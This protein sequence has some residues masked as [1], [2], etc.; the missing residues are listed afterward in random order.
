MTN[1]LG[2]RFSNLGPE[3]QRFQN[4]FYHQLLVLVKFFIHVLSI[5]TT[6][7]RNENCG[8]LSLGFRRG[9][10]EGEN[11]IHRTTLRSYVL[12]SFRGYQSRAEFQQRFS[13]EGVLPVKCIGVKRPTKDTVWKFGDGIS[14]TNM[15]RDI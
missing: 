1:T 7:N 6:R 2:I 13:L 11:D 9:W 4:L 14:G 15:V 8:Q 12:E 3:I 5:P 10:L